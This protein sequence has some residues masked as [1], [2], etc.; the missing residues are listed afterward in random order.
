MDT[1]ARTPM[2]GAANCDKHCELQNS[3]NQQNLE[4]ILCSRDMPESMPASV[5]LALSLRASGLRPWAAV[6]LVCQAPL[7]LGG[8]GRLTHGVRWR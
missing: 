1:S 2:K 4:R 6:L 5:S 3:V 7:P 8:V